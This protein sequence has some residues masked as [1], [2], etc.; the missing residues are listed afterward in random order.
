MCNNFIFPIAQG[1]EYVKAQIERET[2]FESQKM[3]W[4]IRIHLNKVKLQDLQ[5]S[6]RSTVFD[7]KTE[8]SVSTTSKN[9]GHSKA[10]VKSCDVIEIDDDE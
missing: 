5:R 10:I 6:W 1:E 4:A 9:A 8:A 7:D 2:K 3:S